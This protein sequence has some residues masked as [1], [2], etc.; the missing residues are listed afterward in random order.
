[1]SKQTTKKAEEPTTLSGVYE[2]ILQGLEEA[3]EGARGAGELRATVR[4]TED[5]WYS[6]PEA[7]VSASHN[8]S[9][10]VPLALKPIAKN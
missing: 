5:E 9:P 6:D 10:V 1:M 3:I 4:S 2:D 8:A 7:T